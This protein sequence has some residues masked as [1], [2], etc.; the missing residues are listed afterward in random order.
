MHFKRVCICGKVIAQCRCMG[1]KNVQIVYSC[2][3]EYTSPYVTVGSAV[4]FEPITL[5]GMHKVMQMFEDKYGDV[6]NVLRVHPSTYNAI[7]EYFMKKEHEEEMMGVA[8][9]PEFTLYQMLLGVPI[10]IDA[11]LEFGEWKFEKVL[12]RDI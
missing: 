8:K 2:E 12:K 6:P 10:L 7:R 1:E 3:H 9:R 11:E 5:D 4:S